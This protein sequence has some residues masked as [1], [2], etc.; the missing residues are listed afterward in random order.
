MLRKVRV[1]PYTEELRTTSR[2]EA[3]AF[4][5]GEGVRK[6][7]ADGGPLLITASSDT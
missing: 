6:C 1:P 4:F 5:R 2:L 3:R 7:E